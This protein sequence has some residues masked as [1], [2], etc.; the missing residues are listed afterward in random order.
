MTQKLNVAKGLTLVTVEVP[1]TKAVEVKQPTNHIAIIDC[2]GSMYGS[3]P[4]IR[5]HLKNKLPQLVQAGDTVSLVWFS[6]RG[7]YGMLAEKVKV[8]DANDLNRL[9]GAIDRWLQPMSLTGF[10]EPLRTTLDLVKKDTNGVY[11]L[12]FM[13]DG[14]DN[15]WSESEILT[16]TENLKDFVSAAVFVEYGWYCNRP[17]LTKMAERLGGNLIFCEN[18]DAY[19]PVF[20]SSLSKS[21][22]S[23]KKVEIDIPKTVLNDIVFSVD[24]N[25]PCTYKIENG[26]I[27][28]PESVDAIHYYIPSDDGE[29]I[30][31]VNDLDA[32]RPVYQ[33]AVILSQRLKSKTVKQI[34]AGLGDVKLFKKFGNAFGKQN[35]SDFEKLALEASNGKAFA[36]GRQFNLKI[37]EKAFSLCDFLFLIQEDEKNQLVVGAMDYNRIG[38][39]TEQVGDDFTDEERAEIADLTAKAKKP[40][41]FDA[42]KKRIDEIAASKPKPLKFVYDDPNAGCSISNLT[43]NEDRPN[44]SILVRIPGTVELPDNCDFTKNAEVGKEKLPLKFPTFIFRNYTIIKD[45]IANIDE[46]PLKLSKI[47][48]LALKGLGVAGV[49]GDYD[50]EKIYKIDIRSLPTINESMVKDISAKKLFTDA[51][52]LAKLKASEKVFKAFKEQWVGKRESVGYQAKYGTDAEAWLKEQG[53]NEYN[54]FCPK[55]TVKESTDF[56]MALELEVVLKGLSDIP[57]FNKF[58]K[59]VEAATKKGKSLTAS[60]KLLEASNNECEKFDKSLA[61]ASDRDTQIQA[62]ILAKEEESKKAK[63]KALKDMAQIK[64]SII[65]GQTWFTEFATREENTLTMNFDGNDIECKALLKDVQTKI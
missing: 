6:G 36:E 5:T 9:N 22:K 41:D 12:F 50:A 3:L 48:F 61:G 34:L 2:S 62:W 10:V 58:K 60:A 46:M 13:T 29:Q 28:V 49:D 57:S 14:Y 43:W 51:Y 25:A 52:E 40:V 56:Y 24:E 11:S 59:E 20:S 32:L 33:S 53:F 23:A 1:K 21:L 37:D 19:E 45:G 4:L 64:F 55:R 16:A 47:T 17:L 38:R 63:R 7:E 26:K 39:A 31:K 18:I 54:G 15:Q 30:S 35:L 65:L 44:V 8:N 42:V 27:Q